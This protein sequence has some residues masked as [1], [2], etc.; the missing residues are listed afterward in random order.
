MRTFILLPFLFFSFFIQFAHAESLRVN[1]DDLESHLEDYTILDAR[2]P[3]L[4]DS[5]HIKGA[6]NLPSN[7]TYANKKIDGKIIEPNRIQITLRN[8]GIDINT[9]V[10][11]YDDGALVDA[12]RVFW[13]LEVYGLTNVKVLNAGF[14]TWTHKN[15]PI[16]S[17]K[18]DR[19]PSQ[20]IPRVN[21][22]R[23]ATKLSTQIATKNPNQIIIDARGESEYIGKKSSAKRFGHIPSA[24][25][26]PASHNIQMSDDLAS[27]QPVD[28]LKKVYANINKD[29]K[30]VAYCSIGRIT[31]ANYLALREL[32][33]DV[34]IYDA[35]WNE[36]GNDFNLPIIEPSEQ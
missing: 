35:S 8:L 4:Y 33:Y 2:D 21:Q 25:N 28:E 1:I 31:S 3:S 16:D 13:T 32:G 30:V 7:W 20:Y 29:K 27:L 17:D 34:A 5:L 18:P 11:I 26:I 14:D 36:W 6:L 9:P 23:I 12:A 10:V 24:I 22:T 19:N 15:Y